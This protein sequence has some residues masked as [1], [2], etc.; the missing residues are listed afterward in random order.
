MHQGTRR[1]PSLSGLYWPNAGE[2]LAVTGMSRD[3]SQPLPQPV[4]QPR[5]SSAAAYPHPERRHG[6]A[7]VLVQQRDEPVDVVALERVHVPGQQIP[8]RLGE[9]R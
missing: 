3:P 5:S 1:V 6:D 7:G 4:Y 8:V 9:L 2:P